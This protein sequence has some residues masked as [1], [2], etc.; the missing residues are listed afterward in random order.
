MTKDY[1]KQYEWNKENK[2][3]IGL[4]LMRNTDADIIEYIEQKQEKGESKQGCIKKCL[5]AAKALE[6][7]IEDEKITREKVDK[8]VFEALKELDRDIA[9]EDLKDDKV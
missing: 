1:K 6:K 3:F 8:A 2:L 7:S 5:R 9:T 4:N